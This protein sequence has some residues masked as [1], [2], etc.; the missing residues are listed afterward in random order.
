[1][2]H[3]FQILQAIGVESVVGFAGVDIRVTKEQGKILPLVFTF[4]N[5]SRQWKSVFQKKNVN[6]N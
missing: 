2:F 4:Q 6:R 3:N 1:M 5:E